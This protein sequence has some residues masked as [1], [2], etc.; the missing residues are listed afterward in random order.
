MTSHA[1]SAGRARASGRRPE[2]AAAGRGRSAR[3]AS[4]ASARQARDPSGRRRPPAAVL[5]RG[6]PSGARR[7]RR[8]TRRP[9][10]W[11]S[12]HLRSSIWRPKYATAGRNR[13]LWG[14]AVVST[15]LEL[16]DFEPPAEYPWLLERAGSVAIARTTCDPRWFVS[17]HFH[18]S[19]I[20]ADQ[21][22]R[23]TVDGIQISTPNGTVWETDVLPHELHRLFGHDTFVWGGDFNADPRMDDVPGFVGGN[24]RCFAAYET[25]GSGDTRAR[26]HPSFV[27]TFFKAGRRAY[28]LDHVFADAGT[29]ARVT[30]WLV[31]ERPATSGRP[32]STVLPRSCSWPRRVPAQHRSAARGRARRRRGGRDPRRDR[33]AC[34]GRAPRASQARRC[35]APESTTRREVAC[36]SRLAGRFPKV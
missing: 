29:E 25:A 21:V 7:T 35:H 12:D 13:P 15:S 2:S 34:L 23:H 16:L 20:P 33:A 32:S 1:S 8:E 5:T 3:T 24:R 11:A 17:V 10:D 22:G 18:A 4:A 26:F 14:C 9:P 28:Q 6:E 19:Q 27:Q 36:R 31:D 30:G